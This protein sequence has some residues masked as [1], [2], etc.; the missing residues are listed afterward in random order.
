VNNGVQ[1]HG[2]KAGKGNFA[3]F[4]QEMSGRSRLRYRPVCTFSV[5][6]HISQVVWSAFWFHLRIME[7]PRQN[8]QRAS[9]MPK[10]KMHR[11]FSP[12]IEA[13][14]NGFPSCCC[15]FHRVTSNTYEKWLPDHENRRNGC[16][17]GRTEARTL[18]NESGSCE[19]GHSQLREQDSFHLETPSRVSI[20]PICARNEGT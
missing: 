12:S 16:G 9:L 18:I 14:E 11:V 7:E 5:D 6:G 3:S 4:H 17:I 2:F 8:E 20:H 13:G 1:V 19:V 15:A 10:G